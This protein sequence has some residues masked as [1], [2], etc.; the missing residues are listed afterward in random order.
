MANSDIAAPFIRSGTLSP[1]IGLGTCRSAQRGTVQGRI[2]WA[3][4]RN[5][6][7]A[8][9]T[10][11]DRTADLTTPDMTGDR[12]AR[13]PVGRTR[14]LDNGPGIR[15]GGNA[16]PNGQRLDEWVNRSRWSAPE[17][18]ASCWWMST[19]IHAAQMCLGQDRLMDLSSPPQLRL[20]GQHRL[21]RN[22]HPGTVR[23]V[24]AL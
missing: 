5:P 9:R 2:Q 23:F 14:G 19:F 15:S 16:V 13:Q 11:Q 17:G 21:Y 8:D 3:E 7:S 22:R 4:C 1:V 6:P 10:G 12:R 18:A 24:P 20:I